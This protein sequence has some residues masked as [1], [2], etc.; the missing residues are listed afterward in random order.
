MEV[1]SKPIGTTPNHPIRSVD[2]DAFVRADSLSVGEHLQTL[3]GITRVTSITARGPPE[4]VYNLEV[5][6]KH[7]YFVADS[8]VLVH[9]GGLCLKKGAAST[10]DVANS[11]VLNPVSDLARPVYKQ[12][13]PGKPVVDH[14][15]A[16]AAGYH[17]TDPKNLH[18]KPW[19]WNAR[20]GAL[21]G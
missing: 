9:N 14:I 18:V 17:A 7:T 13:H 20:K 11:R 8:G 19:E 21:E 6:V 5:Q 2:R 16:R 1:E 3:N 15:S 12:G 10:D 4:P